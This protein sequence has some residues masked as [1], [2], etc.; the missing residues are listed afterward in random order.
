M[1]QSL[2]E[3]QQQIMENKQQIMESHQQLIANNQKI[4]EEVKQNT[5]DNKN[6]GL[7]WITCLITSISGM[8]V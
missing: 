2:I 3:N 6:H 5:Q 8:K 1:I 4:K 7:S